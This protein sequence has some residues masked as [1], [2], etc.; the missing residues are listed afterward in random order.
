VAIINGWSGKLSR[1]LG[2]RKILPD[3]A[4]RGMFAT[5]AKRSFVGR[6]GR[7]EDIASLTLELMCNSFMTGVVVDVDGGGLL[8]G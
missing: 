8:A 7:P 6:I 1:A 4:R 3:D 5:A 2:S